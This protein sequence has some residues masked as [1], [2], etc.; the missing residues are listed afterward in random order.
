METAKSIINSPLP[1]KCVEA[2]FVALL[3]TAGLPYVERFPLSFQT[4]LDGQVVPLS[5][6]C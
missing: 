2:V 4:V 6:K 5:R 1:I 3:L